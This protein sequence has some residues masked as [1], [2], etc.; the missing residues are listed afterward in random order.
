MTT[1][2]AMDLALE[3][4][5]AAYVP[6]DLDEQREKAIT[7]IEQARALDRKAENA[8]ELGLD[9]EPAGGTQVS[10]VWWDCEKLMSKPIPLEDFCQPAPVQERNFCERCGKRLG[11]GIHT[12]TPPA[13]LVQEPVAWNTGVPPLYSEMKDGET[14]SVEYTTLPAQPAP[15]QPVAWMRNDGKHVTT[16]AYRHN[17]PDYKT[18]Y[19]I[20]LYT[21]PPAAPVQ[22][23]VG[24]VNRYG[25]DSHG[26]KWHGIYWYDP[27]VDVA[28]GTKLYTTPP[29]V[30]TPL[31]AQPAPVQEPVAWT[32][33]LTGEHNGLVGKAGEKFVGA[34]EYYERVDVYTSPPAQRQWVGLTETEVDECYESVMF[35]PDIEPTRVL[36]YQAIE[37]KLRSKNT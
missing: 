10:K 11:S 35:N 17:Y 33:L 6:A 37:A 1:D 31:A 5:K 32:L 23:P 22:E 16:A 7:A 4:L 27:N 19:S 3:I 15:V 29:N 18:R 9:Y 34:P 28:H 8:R 14:I 25:L 26:R 20:P 24:E 12:C 13:E 2:E 21:T 30:A 36:V